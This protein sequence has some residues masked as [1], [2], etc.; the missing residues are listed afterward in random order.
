MVEHLIWFERPIHPEMISELASN[1]RIIEPDS[2]SDPYGRIELG[3]GVIASS[4]P[5]TAKVMDRATNAFVIARTG[6]GYDQIDV[7]AATERGIAVCNTPDG[8][9]VST[10][11]HTLALILAVAKRVSRAAMA[12]KVTEG[13]Y[14]SN[15]QAIE[16]AGKTL[17]LIGFGRIARRVARGA[18]GIGMQVIAYDPLAQSDD[19]F[20]LRVD[21]LEQLLSA[22]DVVSI[23]VPLTPDTKHLLDRTGL[24]LMKQG[25][26]LVNTSRGGVIDQEALLE[27]LDAGHL[28]GAGLDVTD[29]EPLPPEHPLLN[30]A[31]VVVTPHVASATSEGR[32]R[33]FLTAL[34]QAVTVLER[35]RPDHLVNP[36]VWEQVEN[37]MMGIHRGQ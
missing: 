31:D 5:Y 36:E 12:L 27:A 17:G 14:Y 16:L 4:L 26:I 15:H 35:R 24:R 11:E 21:D 37:R 10:A 34:A 20:V 33:I 28:F 19:F 7:D 32:A 8:P 23:H 1:V 22:S 25:A 2:P 29:P 13:N 3:R 9:T 18:Q 6:I 30:R